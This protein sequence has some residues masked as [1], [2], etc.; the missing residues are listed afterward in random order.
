VGDR[1]VSNVDTNGKR[2][3][4]FPVEKKKRKVSSNKVFD[5]MTSSAAVDEVDLTNDGEKSA[6]FPTGKFLGMK[7]PGGISKWM[8]GLFLFAAGG[9]LI[10]P[11]SLVKYTK[12]GTGITKSDLEI[13]NM[14]N[15]KIKELPTTWQFPVFEKVMHKLHKE[16]PEA[17]KSFWKI[18]REKERARIAKYGMTK[19]EIAEEALLRQ[20]IVDFERSL[21]GKENIKIPR[22]PME[23]FEKFKVNVDKLPEILKRR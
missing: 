12:V 11:K 20:K 15:K 6:W 7:V 18:H 9:S 5:M 8:D 4:L 1:I 21:I 13:S 3:N 14:I 2:L 17:F 19:A 23:R 10:N 22:N 16:S